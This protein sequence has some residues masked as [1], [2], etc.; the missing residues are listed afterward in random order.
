MSLPVITPHIVRATPRPDYTL[1]PE[2]A[3]GEEKVFD[4]KPL[5]ST[6]VFGPLREYE[7]F[8]QVQ[9]VRGSLE[10]PG[11]RDLAYDA[12]YEQSEPFRV[13]EAAAR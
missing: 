10:W 5:L 3:S 8:R 2:F 6:Q 7:L 4:M 1:A 9:I 12:L 13:A 11:E